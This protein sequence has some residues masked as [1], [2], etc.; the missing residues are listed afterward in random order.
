MA[1]KKPQR[2][3][4]VSIGKFDILATFVYARG[5]IDGLN[6]GEAKQRGM[7]AAIRSGFG[8]HSCGPQRAFHGSV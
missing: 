7:V 3:G 6:D 2:E 8:R 1:T 5:L 4:H